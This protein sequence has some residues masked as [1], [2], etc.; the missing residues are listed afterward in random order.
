MKA[1]KIR[2][3]KGHLNKGHGISIGLYWTDMPYRTFR[4][5]DIVREMYFRCQFVLDIAPARFRVCP[6]YL[7]GKSL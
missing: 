1:R 6:N 4:F 7:Q 5:L 2:S 3:F